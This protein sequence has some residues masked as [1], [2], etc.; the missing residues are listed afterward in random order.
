MLKLRKKSSTFFIG[1]YGV[2]T[3]LARFYI[4]SQ[5]NLSFIISIT[6]GAIALAFLFILV[7]IGFLNFKDN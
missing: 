5:L 4:E 1:V 7:K 2:L 6:I 3:L